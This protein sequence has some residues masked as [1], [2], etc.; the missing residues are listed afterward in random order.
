MGDR[1]RQDIVFGA[2]DDPE[3]TPRQ[4]R[5]AALAGSVAGAIMGGPV[6]AATVAVGA[7]YAAAKDDGGLG[8]AA[9]SMGDLASN[10]SEKTG[11]AID[12]TVKRSLSKRS[13]SFKFK[14]DESDDQLEKEVRRRE[15]D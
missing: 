6:V 10:L 9:R 2:V 14:D 7:V 5:G 13:S 3:A 1:L 8:D 12:R 15:G 4:I 11:K